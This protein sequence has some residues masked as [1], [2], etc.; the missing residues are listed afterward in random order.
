M[1]EKIEEKEV[2]IFKEI[3]EWSFCILLALI[4]ALLTR[5]YITT[6]TV[7]KQSSM[8]PT[9]KE[10][11]RIMLS[12]TKRITKNEYKVGDII[13]FEAPSE[14]KRGADVDLLNVVAI[15]NYEPEGIIDKLVYYVLELNKLSYIKRV[16]GLE[17]DR[18]Q[19]KDGKVYVNGTELKEEYLPEGTTTKV[20]YYND[21]IVPEGCIYVLGD[22]RDESIDSRT[23]GCI[24]LEKVEG[25]VILR[26]WPL[27]VFGGV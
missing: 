22:N 9:L 16:I 24:P 4:I 17:G 13:T 20:V 2:K 1:K 8:Y 19:I 6:P 27:N 10:D 3:L 12:R 25:K 7:V 5:F 21:V 18:V 26:Y 15:Y 11:Q 23:F 14:I